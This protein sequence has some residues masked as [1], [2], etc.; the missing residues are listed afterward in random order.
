MPA[1]TGMKIAA[2]AS[3]KAETSSAVE[4]TGEPCRGQV[5]DGAGHRFECMDDERDRDPDDDGHPRI[6]GEEGCGVV[7]PNRLGGRAGTEDD[8]AR[9][10]ADRGLN[11][12]VHR[13][14][15]GNLVGH[16]LNEK[17]DAGD[18]HREV[19]REPAPRGGQLDSGHEAIGEPEEEQR[20]PRVEA[21]R[22]GE[23]G[24]DQEFEHATSVG[25]SSRRRGRTPAPVSG[26]PP[27]LE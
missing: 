18:P 6:V 9:R 17:Q 19:A 20:H 13:V 5:G 1:M 8:P 12:V 15:G 14:D 21:R 22:S 16:D 4:T 10:R 25:G 26:A 3:A 7:D 11:H 24:S 2:T 27:T 23:A